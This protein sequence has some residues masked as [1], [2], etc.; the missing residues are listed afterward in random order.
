MEQQ[1]LKNEKSSNENKQETKKP[2]EE[3]SKQKAEEA[4]KT[5]EVADGPK[6]GGWWNR[7]IGE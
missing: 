2:A 3:N 5:E 7:L 4:P 1:N 6:K